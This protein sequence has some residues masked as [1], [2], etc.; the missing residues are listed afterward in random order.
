MSKVFYLDISDIMQIHADVIEDSGGG[1]G[2]KEIDGVESAVAAPQTSYFG[3]AQYPSMAEKAAIL[4]F[5][6]ITRHPF[7]DG[8]KRVGHS[9]MAHFLYMNGYEI[10][11]DDDEQEAIILSVAAGT[12]TQE[13]FAAWLQSKIT[14]YLDV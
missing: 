10:T 14:P 8:N 9:A 1:S 12:M 6:L 13:A 7:V 5:I 3:E 11:A 4:G 2:I